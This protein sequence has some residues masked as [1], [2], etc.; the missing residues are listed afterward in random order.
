MR[1]MNTLYRGHLDICW[2]Y[3]VNLT[4]LATLKSKSFL[5]VGRVNV[6][7]VTAIY[8]RDMAIK[9]FRPEPYFALLNEKR[10]ANNELPPLNDYIKV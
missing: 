1:M 5:R 9:P 10:E 6:P 7:I 8:D 3:G 4:R 2:L